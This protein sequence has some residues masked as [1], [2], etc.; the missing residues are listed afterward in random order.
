MSQR[1]LRLCA[2]GV[3]ATSIA[4]FGTAI[5]TTTSSAADHVSTPASRTV[6]K[7]TAKVATR[8][9]SKVAAA[10]TQAFPSRIFAASSPFYQRLP[11]RTP[12]DNQSTA[13]VRNLYD[14]GVN[15]Y[16]D[17]AG[18]RPAIALNTSSYTPP[19]YV[20]TNSDP[21]VTFSWENCQGKTYGDFGLIAKHLTG[22]RIPANALP[23]EGTD[24]EMTIYNQDTD[25]YTDTWVTRKQNGR[26]SACWAGTIRNASKNDG[27]FESPF[28]ASASGIALAA[29]VIRAD[30]LKAG[31]IDH[32]VGL[33]MPAYKGWPSVSWPANRTDGSEPVNGRPAPSAGQLLRLP[34]DLNIDAMKLSPV[35]RTIAK[36]A[37]EYGLIIWDTAGAIS[38]RLENPVSMGSD[39]YPSIMRGRAGWDE[40]WGDPSR[41]EQMFPL[42]K[43]EVLPMNYRAP[44]T[45]WVGGQPGQST[46]PS[47]PSTPAPTPAPSTPTP[48][49]AGVGGSD[50]GS[51]NQGRVIVRQA[52]SWS[53]VKDS[54]GNTWTRRGDFD[55]L[56]TST[57]LARTGVTGTADQALYAQQVFGL[58]SYTKAVPNGRY[59]VTVFMAEDWFTKPGE[60]VFDITAEGSTVSAGVDLV[61][62]TGGKGRATSV[63]ADVDVRD[64]R[65]DLG[66]VPIKDRAIVAGVQIAAL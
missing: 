21:L 4:V 45:N 49:P 64:G 65:L 14:Q 38:F 61:A 30:E 13:M 63:S 15:Y 9:T 48:P 11:D 59:R 41:G 42:D 32:V 46:A 58:R 44:Q 40:M 43:L 36:A 34:A 62:R 31:R 16:G 3:V 50:A 24:A 26:W 12:T 54:A 27:V 53:D 29:G 33:A 55:S 7:A 19:M 66:F 25:E 23:A 47:V 5:G 39:P 28:G 51:G 37:Q 10:R 35:A 6:A 2:T 17:K 52:A 18:R 8:T 22:I 1:R 56:M 20:A 57:E 60:R